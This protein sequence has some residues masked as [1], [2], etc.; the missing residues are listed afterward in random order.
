[1]SIYSSSLSFV[2][3]HCRIIYW[4]APAANSGVVRGWGPRTPAVSTST[5]LRPPTS[6]F[7]HCFDHDCFM[8][9]GG[10]D[11]DA[12]KIRQSCDLRASNWSSHGG[13]PSTEL[14]WIKTSSADIRISRIY[15]ENRKLIRLIYG[16]G[17]FKSRLKT[18]LQP[19][20]PTLTC[21]HP[22]L[23]ILHF[24]NDLTCDINRVIN[25]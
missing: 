3:V 6:S 7:R 13:N 18:T 2:Y 9:I 19:G 1:M 10:C 22:A 16:L 24:V 8:R 25:K 11:C 5:R 12:T 21:D 17:T 20:F 23:A 4:S 15:A 14:G